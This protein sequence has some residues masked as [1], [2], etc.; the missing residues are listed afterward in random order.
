MYVL[1]ILIVVDVL[2]LFSVLRRNDLDP[3]NKVVFT[4]CIILLPIV[5]IIIYYLFYQVE[6]EENLIFRNVDE[7][8]MR[9]QC[10]EIRRYK[11]NNPAFRR[12]YFVL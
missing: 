2:G 12:G 10:E 4:L 7:G 9:K 1:L 3:I 11:T 6:K 8:A 5:G